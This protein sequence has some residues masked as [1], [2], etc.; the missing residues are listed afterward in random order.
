MYLNPDIVN[1]NNWYLENLLKMSLQA[2]LS[3][4]L[5]SIHF[6][7]HDV[8]HTPTITVLKKFGDA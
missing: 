1:Y 8:S 2:G 4:Y 3:W 6:A 7:Y 5:G